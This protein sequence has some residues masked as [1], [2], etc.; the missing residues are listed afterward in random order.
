MGYT[1]YFKLEKKPSMVKWNKFVK[2]CKLLHE[3]LPSHTDTAG[4]YSKNEVLEIC[5]GNGNG[6]PEFTG[7]YICFNGNEKKNLEHETF[8]IERNGKFSGFCK[9]ARKPYDLLAFTCL[10]AANRTLGLLYASDGYTDYQGVK[11]CNDLLPAM[12]FYNEVIKPEVLVSEKELWEVRNN[13][14]N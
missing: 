13:K 1:H 4:G 7:E 14:Y 10:I 6:K 12:N 5:G 8:Y 3:N 2:E 11:E 9:T